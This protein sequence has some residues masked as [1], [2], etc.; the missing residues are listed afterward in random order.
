MDVRPLGADSSAGRKRPIDCLAPRARLGERER[1]RGD[2]ERLSTLAGSN[3][4][5]ETG[6]DDVINGFEFLL[7]LVGQASSHDRKAGSDDEVGRC[8]CVVAQRGEINLRKLCK[9]HSEVLDEFTICIDANLSDESSIN[10]CG[11]AN[12]HADHLLDLLLIKRV[13]GFHVCSMI[14]SVK[15]GGDVPPNVFGYNLTFRVH[16]YTPGIVLFDS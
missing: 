9:K 2:G 14:P 5:W 7:P 6:E 13:L 8:G 15:G 3:N 1:G 4:A 10:S 12:L 11:G 16:Y